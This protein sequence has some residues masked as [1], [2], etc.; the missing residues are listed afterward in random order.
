MTRVGQGMFGTVRRRV[1]PLNFAVAV[2]ELDAP[3]SS[4][5]RQPLS[6]VFSEVASL[7]V[8]SAANACTSVHDY[9]F[10]GS[11][12]WIMMEWCPSSLKAWRCGLVGSIDE[13]MPLLLRTYKQVR[14]IVAI[15]LCIT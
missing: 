10:D 5:D 12:W 15:S 6:V 3:Q 14:Q 7:E 9:G 4:G 13:L 8:V 11:S 2:K 1:F